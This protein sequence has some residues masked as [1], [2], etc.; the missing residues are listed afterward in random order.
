MGC[1]SYLCEV[2]GDPVICDGPV[3]DRVKLWMLRDGKP[4]QSMEGMYSGYGTV[5]DDNGDEVKWDGDWVGL[6]D[7]AFNDNPGDGWAAIHSRC[8]SKHTQVPITR[9]DD[10]PNQG[11]LP[12]PEEE[13]EVDEEDYYA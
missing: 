3:Q 9:S 10:D 6:V 4:V 13:E 1:F 11:W 12:E 7:M 5:N 8:F 2:C